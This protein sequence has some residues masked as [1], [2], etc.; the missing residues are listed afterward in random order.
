M[1]EDYTGYVKIERKI[2]ILE[3]RL[4]SQRT[5]SFDKEI[6]I[7][8]GTGYCIQFLISLVLMIISLTYRNVPVIIFEDKFNF[9]PF[10]GIMKFPTGVDGAISVPIW[11]FVSV[12]TFRTISGYLKV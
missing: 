8:Y 12:F 6:L 10:G 4:S 1:H 11:S 7:N 2:V 5:S 3:Q 9:A